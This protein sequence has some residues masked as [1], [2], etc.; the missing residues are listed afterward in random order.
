MS[1]CTGTTCSFGRQCVGGS[2][3]ITAPLLVIMEAPGKVELQQGLPAVGP[4]GKLMDRMLAAANI[5]RQDEV[6]VINTVQCVEIGRRPPTP[7]VEEINSCHSRLMAD[8]EQSQAKI[9]LCLGNTAS[10]QLLPELKITPARGKFRKI[11]D[12]LVLSSY[13]PSAV[14][15]GGN[16]YSDLIQEDMGRVRRMLDW[17]S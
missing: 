6:R 9:I 5:S 16:S 15:H 1:E 3:K 4:A 11:G 10:Q 17:L 14:L 12:K 8:I 2:G 13:H 7:T